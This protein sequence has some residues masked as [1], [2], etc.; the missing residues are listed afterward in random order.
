MWTETVVILNSKRLLK[1]TVSVF[2][3]FSFSWI[4]TR[5]IDHKLKLSDGKKVSHLVVW[6]EI[7][8]SSRNSRETELLKI[9]LMPGR[10]FAVKNGAKFR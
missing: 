2:E 1:G 4:S 9:L 5:N 10:T 7:N 8:I 6:H 3:Q